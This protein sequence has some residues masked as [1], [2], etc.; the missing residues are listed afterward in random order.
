MLDDLLATP[1]EYLA[2]AS[3][4]DVEQARAIIGELS[5]PR[6]L[7]V[8]LS[9]GTL[10]VEPGR[11]RP[12]GIDALAELDR[13]AVELM[14]LPQGITASAGHGHSTGVAPRAA[15][16]LLTGW[17]LITVAE[18]SELVGATASLPVR[19]WHLALIAFADEPLDPSDPAAV[20]RDITAATTDGRL[21]TAT[22]RF[23]RNESEPA[24]LAARVT[25]R[26]EDLGRSAPLAWGLR[27]VL[28]RTADVLPAA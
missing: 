27:A 3:Q 7:E 9:Q 8:V 19:P 24:I 15:S 1:E 12:G 25:S 21:V 22:L 17:E 16:P 11:V 26:L 13:A 10:A 20:L 2:R 14:G 6:L 23:S 4:H 5:N 28:G 18:R